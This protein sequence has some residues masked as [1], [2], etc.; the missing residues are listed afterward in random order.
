MTSPN[1]VVIVVDDL[2]WRDLGCTGSDFYQTPQIDALAAAGVTFTQAYSAAPN[3]S[4]SRASLLTGRAPARIGLTQIVGGHGVGRLADVP[5][6][7]QLP[8]NEYTYARAFR[9]AGYR[10]W[11]VGKWH[12]G[13]EHSWPQRHGFDVNVGG[14]DWGSPRTYLSPYGCP[15]LDD[16][17]SRRVPHRSTDHRGHRVDRQGFSRTGFRRGLTSVPAEP[18]ALRGAHTAAGSQ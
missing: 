17:P 9:A 11:H 13:P 8:R 5:S 6:F 4:P 14:C 15:T 10:T 2:G 7:G 12:L 1:V 18:V 3:C 16:G